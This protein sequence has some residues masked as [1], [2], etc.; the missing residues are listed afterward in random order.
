MRPNWKLLAKVFGALLALQFTMFIVEEALQTLMFSSWIQKPIAPELASQIA[1][2]Y[3]SV[4]VLGKAL[5]W[6]IGVFIPPM[7]LAYSAYWK[8]GEVWLTSFCT[9]NGVFPEGELWWLPLLVVSFLATVLLSGALL[10]FRAPRSSKGGG[11]GGRL[12]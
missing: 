10:L 11:K 1:A 2:A 4:L 8:A 7:F 9:A 6:A 3:H 12:W 5:T